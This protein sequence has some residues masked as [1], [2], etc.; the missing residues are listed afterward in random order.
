MEDK[1]LK[2]LAKVKAG[3]TVK[4]ASIDAG[5][6]LNSRLTSM[7]LLPNV[8]LTVV[9]NGQPRPFVTS[10]KDSLMMLG[11]GMVHKIIVL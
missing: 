2:P 1:Q 6:G 8:E 7:R 10:V 5:Q 9:S 4:L 3:E 11:R